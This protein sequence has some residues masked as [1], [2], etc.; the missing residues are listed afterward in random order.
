[1]Q[2]VG[3]P[4]IFRRLWDRTLDSYPD[5]RR[6]YLNL[7]IVVL[8]TIVL[9]YEFYVPAAVTPSIIADFG[10]TWPFFVYVIVVANLVGAFASL[11]AGLADRWGRS[12]LVTYGLLI[13]ALV[14][15]FGLPNAPNLWVYAV[16]YCTLGFVE[17]IILVATPALVRDFSPQL[18]RGLATGFWTMGPVVASL[19]VALVS[20][21]TLS[22]LH[23]WQDQ[24]IICGI[25]GLVV[26]AIALVGLRELSP[27]L[28]A[29]LM[30][31][32]RDRQLIEA[33]AAGID[34]EERSRHPWRQ[35]LHL[36]IVGP[37]LGIGVFLVVYYTLIA[38]LVVYMATIFG[39]TE[40]R[41]NALGNWVWAFNAGALV[42]VGLLSDRL[43]V[44]KPLMLIGI[45][46]SI[47]ATVLFALRTNHPDTGYY[48][49]VWILSLLAVFLALVFTPWLAAF[50]ETVEGRNPALMATGLAVWGWTLR[51]IVAGSLFAL[52]YVVTSMTPLVENGSQVQALVARYPDEVATLNAIDPGTQAQLQA[53]P[54]NP[55]AISSAVTEIS[56]TLHVSPSV[57]LQDLTAVSRVPRDDLDFLAAHGPQVQRPAAASPGEW[58]RW[59]WICVGGEALLLPFLFVMR[60]R[61][62]PRRARADLEQHEQAV[63]EE[64]A[65]LDMRPAA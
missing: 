41:A 16:L 8:A 1:M 11:I 48:T 59:W 33:R 52:P 28:R 2:L 45:A 21:H 24:F 60:G 7:G 63:R 35:M 12:N 10:I 6:R 18:G 36:D 40:Q 9:Y 31:Q 19:T 29:Q 15:L 56:Q 58:R 44:R 37:S 20:S 38:F 65:A 49:F 5:N 51:L 14:V 26:F 43:L 46:G 57:A 39:Y 55:A 3:S 42:L 30:V 13:T 27:Q 61:W 23:A 47:V 54:S 22:H 50:T 62:S 32:T 17:G 4:S 34:I 53:D 64:L 25:V